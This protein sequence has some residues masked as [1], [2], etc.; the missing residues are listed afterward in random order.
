MNQLQNFRKVHEGRKYTEVCLTTILYCWDVHASSQEGKRKEKS[1]GEPMSPVFILNCDSP[2]FR[3]ESHNY[4]IFFLF[5]WVQML[6]RL[7]ELFS[8]LSPTSP[9][10][11]WGQQTNLPNL[12]WK[13]PAVETEHRATGTI[14]FVKV[15]PG[16]TEK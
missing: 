16:T 15:V 7:Q 11:L 8:E 1:P 13:V 12:A 2:F 14:W 4:P 10:F 6:A 9:S 3:W 5:F